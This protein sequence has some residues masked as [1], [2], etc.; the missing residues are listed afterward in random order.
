MT[1]LVQESF[2]SPKG[3]SYCKPTFMPVK[4]KTLRK[5]LTPVAIVSVSGVLIHVLVPLQHQESE[6]I[7]KIKTIILTRRNK[8]EH[9]F[10]LSQTIFQYVKCSLWLCYHKLVRHSF[11]LCLLQVILFEQHRF[12]VPA[13][14]VPDHLKKRIKNRKP[15]QE[16]EL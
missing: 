3:S 1:I 14:R 6:T 9:V 13:A 2:I 7:L 4:L 15:N 16:S 8:I 12:V 11:L 10:P 5:A